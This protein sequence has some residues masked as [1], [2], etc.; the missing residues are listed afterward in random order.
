MGENQRMFG[1]D[2]TPWVVI[3]LK[4]EGIGN[5]EIAITMEDA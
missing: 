4:A 1:N 3:P 5:F 2:S